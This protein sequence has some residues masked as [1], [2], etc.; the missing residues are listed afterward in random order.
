LKVRSALTILIILVSAV[1]SASPTNAIGKYKWWDT[2]AT[3]SWFDNGIICWLTAKDTYVGMKFTYSFKLG[4]S[5]KFVSLGSGVSIPGDTQVDSYGEIPAEDTSDLADACDDGADA[6]AFISPKTPRQGGAY[7]V[8]ITT[9]DKKGKFAWNADFKVLATYT[10]V[11]ST[12]NFFTNP[13]NIFFNEKTYAYIS[14]SSGIK[15][16]TSKGKGRNACL[17]IYDVA[18]Q[19]ARTDCP[20]KSNDLISSAQSGFL[21]ANVRGIVGQLA[22]PTA[23]K[24]AP[25]IATYLW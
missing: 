3:G 20:I 9:Y 18:L 15:A 19:G 7:I 21:G 12:S 5:S 16:Y 22:I 14:P 23:I 25:W 8:K 10:G 1:F 24:C 17:I 11:E 4:Q 6:V 13:P 2:S